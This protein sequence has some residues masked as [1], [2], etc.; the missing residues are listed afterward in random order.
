MSPLLERK[1]SIRPRHHGTSLGRCP[2][3]GEPSGC[4]VFGKLCPNPDPVVSQAQSV[5]GA[6]AAHLAW[7]LQCPL[8]LPAKQAQ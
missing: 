4:P 7:Q 5:L 8:S 1:H 3:G 2:K 6:H